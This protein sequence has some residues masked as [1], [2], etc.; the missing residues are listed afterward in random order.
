[1]THEKISR[2]CGNL[3]QL[4]NLTVALG[5]KIDLLPFELASKI[6]D[7]YITLD[8]F[9]MYDSLSLVCVNVDFL[10]IEGSRGS[11][12]SLDPNDIFEHFCKLKTFQLSSNA[13]EVFR[14][15]L[16]EAI[17]EKAKNLKS[18]RLQ[19]SSNDY[20]K[21]LSIGQEGFCLGIE[22]LS[23]TNIDKESDFNR[24]KG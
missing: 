14:P 6:T 8:F 24:I 9:R 4:Q 20:A 7:L 18:L 22:G 17:K 23:I 21:T 16:S 10:S 5:L 19:F 3:N 13:F 11:D 1:M 12:V 2:L 15:N